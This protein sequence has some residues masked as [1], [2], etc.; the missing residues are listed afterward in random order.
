MTEHSTAPAAA[1][2]A[3][4]PQHEL[5]ALIA[6]VA[7]L[8]QTSLAMAKHCLDIQ[9]RLPGVVNAAI[10]AG[11]A[12]LVPASGPVWVRGVAL[13]PDQLEAAYPEGTGDDLAYHI[14]TIGR[15]PGLYA[16]VPESN[17]QVLGVP[18][19][20]R[21]KKSSRMEALAYYRA[22]YAQQ[23]VEKWVP[24]AVPTASAAK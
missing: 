21:L 4:N 12:S 1:M 2:S 16:S 19:S 6:T 23:E 15:D 11:L 10:A 5:D 14:V 9:T 13:T 20:K 22:K 24:E 17:Y 3:P 7:A 8:S 18:N